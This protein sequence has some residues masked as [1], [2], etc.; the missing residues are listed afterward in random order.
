MSGLQGKSF[1]A[2][3]RE[4]TAILDEDGYLAECT[5]TGPGKWRIAEHNCAIL[6]VAVRYRMACSSEIAFLR[7][8]LPDAS[9]E[10]VQHIASGG[11]MCAYEVRQDRSGQLTG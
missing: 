7:E 2:R 1:D 6:D 10:R 3:V 11:H 8:A 9:I 5:Q 4:L